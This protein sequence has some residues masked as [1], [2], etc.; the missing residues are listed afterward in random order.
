MSHLTEDASPSSSLIVPHRPVTRG[1]RRASSLPDDSL[2]DLAV[3]LR[4]R[5]A[6]VL[7][8]ARALEEWPGIRVVAMQD[9]ERGSVTIAARRASP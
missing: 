2:R 3:I 7:E 4:G 8:V 5:R 6:A 9:A 1:D